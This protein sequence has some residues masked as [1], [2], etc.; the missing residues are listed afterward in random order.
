MTFN[1]DVAAVV[2]DERLQIVVIYQINEKHDVIAE[3]SNSMCGRHCD[4]EGEDVVDKCVKRLVHKCTPRQ[5]GHRF[6]LIVD[7]QLRQHE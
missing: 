4:Y 2:G 3:A 1:A 6:Q 5:R 7:E